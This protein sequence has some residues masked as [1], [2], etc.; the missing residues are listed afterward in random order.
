MANEL[1]EVEIQR[2]REA[3]RQFDKDNNGSIDVWELSL[4]LEGM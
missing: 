1:T 3:F 4:A 2:C